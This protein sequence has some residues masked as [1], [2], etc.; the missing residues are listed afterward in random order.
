MSHTLIIAEA[1]VNHNGS[2]ENAKKLVDAAVKAGADYVK[3]QTFKAEKI[4]SKEAGKAA[5]QQ[6]NTGTSETQLEM[7]RKLELSEAAHLELIEYCKS[8]GIQFLSTPFDLESIDLLKK[9]GVTLGKVP[10]GEITNLPY[11]RKMAAAFTHLIM[12][13]GMAEMAEIKAALEVLLKA[14]MSRQQITVLHCN[15]EYPTPMAD[16]NLRAMLT[17]KEDIKVEI[18]Y[19]D[20]TP[21]IEVPIAA[22]ALGA[23]VIEKHFTLDRN[24]EGP[25]HKASLEPDELLNMVS[26]I[27]NIEKALGNNVKTPSAS[28]INNIKIV[29]KSIVAKG[30]IAKG[31][32]FTEENLTV[33]RPGT[34]ISPMEWDNVIGRIAAK[35]FREDEMITL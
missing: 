33:K 32:P 25:D 24:M 6:K 2:L 23:T 4:V 8:K 31:D 21:G 15:T 11:L 7:L 27:R 18:G 10:S 26:S 13:T 35:D 22:V 19:S 20:H 9:L 5:Y 34:G 3:F 12:S 14:G 28:E 1:G 17:I 30:P 16:V 29:R